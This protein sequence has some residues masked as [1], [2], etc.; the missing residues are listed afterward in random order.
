MYPEDAIMYNLRPETLTRRVQRNIYD[1]PVMMCMAPPEPKVIAVF[2]HGGP[3]GR[4][5]TTTAER[6]NT[7]GQIYNAAQN[8]AEKYGRNFVGRVI[9]PGATSASGV[10]NGLSFITQH[11][12]N[13][14]QVILYAY[15]YGVDVSVDLAHTLHANNIPVSLLVTVDGS[16]GPAQNW[17]VNTSIPDNVNVNV[18]YYQTD[19]SGSSSLSRSGA[20]IFSSSESSQSDSGSSNSPGSNG[21]PNSAVNTANVINRNVTANGTTHG[22]IQQK[23]QAEIEQYFDDYIRYYHL[24]R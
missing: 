13:G 23:H 17:T 21:G 22:N 19:D 20:A 7:T 5:R 11:Y 18:N 14:D 1:A 12:N 9:A 16:D 8:S 24:Y 6:A 15:S 4:G 3:F 10:A 2:Y